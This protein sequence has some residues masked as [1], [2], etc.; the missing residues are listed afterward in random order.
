MRHKTSPHRYL[1][2]I[3]TVLAILAITLTTGGATNAQMATAFDPATF[4]LALQPVADGFERPVDLVDAG[5]GSGRLFVV[6]QEGRI[7][8]VRDGAVAKQPFLDLT[9][10]VG[11]CGERG[12]LSLV[13]HPGYAENGLLYVDYTDLNGD[14]Q[15]IRF[16]VAADDPDRADPA[17]ATTILTVEQPASNHNGGRLRFGPDGYLYI[18]LGDGGGGNGQNGQSLE[19]LL[20]KLLRIDVDHQANGQPYAIPADNP[21][22]DTPNARPEIW[23]LGLRNPWRFDFDRV[24]G[25]IWIGDV[26]SSTYEEVNLLPAGSGGG[27]NFGWD[28]M[29]GNDCRDAEA[30]NNCADFVAPISGFDRD[31]GCVV[32]GGTVYRGEQ[33]PALVGIYLFADYCGSGIWGLGRD[34]AGNWVTTGPVAAGSHVVSFGQD[35]VGELYVVDLDG[36]ISRIV[37]ST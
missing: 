24:T 6:E 31:A 33:V 13:F 29:E 2:T 15:I 7:L 12:L 32:T 26:G 36:T 3:A 34:A 18:S 25:D 11:C 22:V 1:T 21:F 27:Q 10:R 30:T 16:G 17:T 5:D 28:A 35:A 37:G 9:D 4:D 19:T 8:I 14:T 23:A 20:G